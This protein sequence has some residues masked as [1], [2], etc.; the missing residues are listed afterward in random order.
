MTTTDKTLQEFSAIWETLALDETARLDPGVTQTVRPSMRARSVSAETALS[1]LPVLTAARGAEIARPDERGRQTLAEIEVG[2]LIGEGGM[3]KVSRAHQSSVAREVAVKSLR[4]DVH[5][6]E[7]TLVLLREGW[8]TGRLEHPNIVPVYA[9]GRDDNGEPLIVMKK[10]AGVSF[11]QLLE[12]PSTSPRELGTKQP[13]D[14]YLETLVQVCNAVHFAHSRGIVHRDIKPE[15]IMVGEFGEVY[16]LD[17]GI[18]VSL[19]DSDD[20]GRLP[21]AA[22][23]TSP[24]GTPAYM[25]PEM[26]TGD[27]ADLSAKTDVFL[28]GAVL[29]EIL[30]GEPPNQGETLFQ[31]MFDAFNAAPGAYGEDVHPE[32]A[33]I[34]GKAMHPEPDQRYE[35]AEMLRQALV[36]HLSHRDSLRLSDMATERLETLGELLSPDHPQEPGSEHELYKVFGECRFGFEQALEVSPDNQAARD[37]LQRALEMLASREIER[38]AYQAAALLIADLRQ[39]NE[40]LERSLDE[41]SQRLASRDRE[42]EDLRRNQYEQDSDVG[43][44]PRSVYAIGLVL[45]WGGL[46]ALAPKIV[47][48]LGF[49]IDAYAYLG[50][51]IFVLV[52]TGVPLLLARRA[53]MQNAAN[54]KLFLSLFWVLVAA[55]V[56]RG[57]GAVFDLPIP[58][59]AVFELILYGGA[60]A[61]LSE[62]FDRSFLLMTGACSAGLISALILPQYIVFIVISSV[63]VGTLA[64]AVAWW[65]R[66]PRR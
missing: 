27:G 57:F 19:D 30:T 38:E 39:P 5:D 54:R 1:Q 66:G 17:W 18:A 14:F 45:A 43:R 24:A 60:A 21:L 8:V 26:V 10:I 13:L 42:F 37:G 2:S 15:N 33:A 49:E 40:E 41:L 28:L 4:D 12:D 55:A 61:V 50:H 9:L 29:H 53:L 25:A 52:I 35:S 48:F 36:R 23:V 31:I 44:H 51:S 22:D 7:T 59:T 46:A 32:L 20:N 16:L 3:G 34:C 11:A 56:A 47:Q 58:V 6:P 65:S 63:L 62:F 64:L